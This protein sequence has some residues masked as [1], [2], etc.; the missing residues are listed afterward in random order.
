M[1]GDNIMKFKK[2]ILILCTALT[3]IAGTIFILQHIADNYK[4]SIE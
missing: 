1:K 3:S 2:F 4:E